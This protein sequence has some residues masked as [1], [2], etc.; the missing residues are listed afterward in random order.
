M[1]L[2]IYKLYSDAH[3]PKYGTE[4][5]A[6]FDL[7]A[8]IHYQS[9]IKTYTTNNEEMTMLA[10]QEADNKP[11]IELPGHWRGLIPTGLIFDIPRDYCVKVYP[12]SGISTK[13][14]L[15]LINCVGIIDSDYVEQV[16]IPIYNNSQ[17][18]VRIYNGDRIA[19]AEMVRVEQVNINFI[20]ARPSQKTNRMGGFG[21]TGIEI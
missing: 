13:Q 4:N 2:N 20:D 10:V 19:Q 1:N 3:S 11:F 7:S 9:A 6:C 14:G 17:N 16:F 18:R 8:Y 21:S 15:N 5:A 12:R